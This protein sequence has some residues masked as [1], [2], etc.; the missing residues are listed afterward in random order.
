MCVRFLHVNSFSR[1]RGEPATQVDLDP[2]RTHDETHLLVRLAQWF[3]TWV[4]GLLLAVSLVAGGGTLV[5][6]DHSWVGALSASSSALAAA[7]FVLHDRP[8]ILSKR[9]N[10]LY[11][12]P[13]MAA[14]QEAGLVDYDSTASGVWIVEE[15]RH[16][17]G[18]FPVVRV[19][20]RTSRDSTWQEVGVNVLVNRRGDVTVTVDVKREQVDAGREVAVI[21]T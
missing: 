10:D 17:K 13:D 1:G 7:G 11:W 12:D 2:F 14:L 6:S 15:S 5:Y 8:K 16:R 20:E 9:W 19:T 3:P 21:F 18:R 4:Y